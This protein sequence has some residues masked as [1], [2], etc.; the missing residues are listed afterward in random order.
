MIHGLRL[1]RQDDWRHIV[2]LTIQP[3]PHQ[4]WQFF[5]W[6]TAIQQNEWPTPV[7]HQ[8]RSSRIRVEQRDCHVSHSKAARS[9]RSQS[10][11]PTQTPCS[12]ISAEPTSPGGGIICPRVPAHRSIE[13]GHVTYLPTCS[14]QQ[15]SRYAFRDLGYRRLEGKGN[16][17]NDA[18]K[19]AATR[20]GFTFE[21]LSLRHYHY[22]ITDATGVQRGS[23]YRIPNGREGTRLPLN[24][25][26]IR[27]IAT[28]SEDRKG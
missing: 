26:W 3:T 21:G 15:P 7:V 25:A 17:L 13:I 9:L 1:F 5:N 11:N 20:Y 12:L 2:S 6:L 16:D 22:I 8:E 18:S 27:A 24:S 4:H 19:K 28:Q 10:G 14:G 23:R